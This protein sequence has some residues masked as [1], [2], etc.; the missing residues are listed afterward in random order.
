MTFYGSPHAGYFDVDRVDVAEDGDE[1]AVTLYLGNDPAVAGP[2]TLIAVEQDVTVPLSRPVGGRRVVDG[3]V[4]LSR[5]R[6]P[7]P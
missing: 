2:V 7:G 4:A 6:R 5:G 3:C 1:V